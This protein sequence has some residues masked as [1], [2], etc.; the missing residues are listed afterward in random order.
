MSSSSIGIL[1]YGMANLRSVQNGFA[2]AG[3]AARIISTADEIRHVD[4]V[5]LPGVGAFQDADGG[6]TLRNLANLAQPSIVSAYW[7]S[8]KISAVSAL[9]GG[10]AGFLI[11]RAAISGGLPGW[12]RPT[13]LTFSGVASQFAGVPLA[14]AFLATLGRT[15]LVTTLLVKYLG[16]KPRLWLELIC[17]AIII[18]FLGFLVVEGIRLTILNKERIFGDSTLSYAWVTSAVPVGC[19]LLAASIAYNMLDAW[20]R[21]RDQLLV[22]TLVQGDERVIDAYFGRGRAAA[23]RG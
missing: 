23:A 10:L 18:V 17:G 20:R 11:A 7:I 9:I 4:R 22:Y 1:D 8:I 5:V 15:G 13:L 19:A 16:Y 12:V 2:Q 6:F 21:R 14:F 3:H